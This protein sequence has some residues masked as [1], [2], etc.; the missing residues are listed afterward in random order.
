MAQFAGQQRAVGF[1]VEPVTSIMIDVG[2]EQAETV[3]GLAMPAEELVLTAYDAS[4]T[5]VAVHHKALR[6]HD[7]ITGQMGVLSLQT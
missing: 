7:V 5:V 1:N 2:V 6:G 3:D 4:G